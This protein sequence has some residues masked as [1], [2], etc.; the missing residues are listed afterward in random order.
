MKAAEAQA[1]ADS[2]CP[3][4][5]HPA[6]GARLPALRRGYKGGRAEMES[7]MLRLPGGAGGS[8]KN[9]IREMNL[10]QRVGGATGGQSVT[11]NAPI[12]VNGVAPGRES[13]MA[14]KTALA[15]RD[16]VAEGLRLMREMQAQDRRT[17]FA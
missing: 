17:N 5:R 7:A 8:L 3:G 13:L 2:A 14:K 12:T 1:Q 11:M 15:L 9:L 16:P 10:Q 4:G 6:T